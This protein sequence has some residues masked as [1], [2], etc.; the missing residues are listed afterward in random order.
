M[1]NSVKQQATQR[2]SLDT[3]FRA[4]LQRVDPYQ[5]VLDHVRL[6]GSI[7]SVNVDADR[8]QLDLDAFTEIIVL[9]AGKATAPMARAME[10][11]LGDRLAAGLIVVKYG[12]TEK[13]QTIVMVEAGHPVPDEQGVMGAGKLLELAEK[14][15]DSSLVINLI[16]GGGSALLPYPAAYMENDSEV[17]LTLADKQQ[18]TQALL[19]CGAE[20]AEINCVRK[21]LSGIKGGR[22]L[23][24]LAPARSISFILSDV[25][26]D[27][28]S[29]I[30]SGLTAADP[31]TF[32]DA[33]GVVEK[34]GIKKNVPGT[35][36]GYLRAGVRGEL[37][38]SLKEGATALQR[39][40]NVLM[41][42]NGTAL[43]A[44]AAKAKELGYTVV[45]L[46]SRI[47]GEA[48]EVAK[49][50]AA[51]A[52]DSRKHSML[53][54]APLCIISGGEP[55][56]TLQGAGKGGRNQEMALAFLQEMQQNPELYQGVSFLAA[57]TDGNDGP[58]DA[59]GAF[60]SLEL[61]QRCKD[62]QMDIAKFL[63]NNDSYHLYQAID[64]LYTTGPTNTNVCDLHVI[65]ID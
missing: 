20:I 25:V 65:L 18:T 16:S 38:E 27:E 43:N 57:S 11:I 13:L 45:R 15:G 28:L 46:T 8:L 26:G 4:G 39:T 42:T 23:E 31:T 62:K 41:G 50:L 37:A 21:H 59:A 2:A 58:T 47:T 9:G 10:E 7:L 49:M 6:E 24:K 5:M 40:T 48:C 52:V 44:S 19:A 56:V 34:Y 55:V 60:A 61:L 35:V 33:L 17:V 14:A 3:I 53:G 32:T 51:I 36:L 30:A 1:T 29:S 22:L 54:E 64:G 63:S 12:H